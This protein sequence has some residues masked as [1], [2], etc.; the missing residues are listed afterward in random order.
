V[1]ATHHGA[2]TGIELEAHEIVVEYTSRVVWE[3]LVIRREAGSDSRR[4][5]R[6][7]TVRV[8]GSHVVTVALA[9]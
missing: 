5:V 6:E 9:R 7:M 8:Y 4:A 2:G 3:E 1:Q